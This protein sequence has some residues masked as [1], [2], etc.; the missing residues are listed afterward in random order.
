MIIMGTAI[1]RLCHPTFAK[2]LTMPQPRGV[3]KKPWFIRPLTPEQR[4]LKA[5]TQKYKDA[6]M[7]D[8]EAEERARKEIS[9]TK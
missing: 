6:G 8:E 2:E 1:T 9:E 3:P 4:A 7:S 5:L